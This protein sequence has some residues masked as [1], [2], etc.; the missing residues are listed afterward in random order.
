MS[1]SLDV[2]RRRDHSF[3]VVSPDLGKRWAS[4][5]LQKDMKKDGDLSF[6]N[7]LNLI[8]NIYFMGLFSK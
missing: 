5:Y 7:L 4:H 6:N 2:P 8:F 1:K 3:K